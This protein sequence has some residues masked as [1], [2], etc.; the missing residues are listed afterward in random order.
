M[1][2]TRFEKPVLVPMSYERLDDKSNNNIYSLV[3]ISQSKKEA[4]ANIFEGK[5][6][7]ELK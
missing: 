6:L 1:S 7:M 4:K 5:V 2:T 3:S